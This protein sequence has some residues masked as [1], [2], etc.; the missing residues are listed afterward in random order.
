LAILVGLLPFTFAGIGTR[1]AAIVFFYR[2]FLSAPVAAA[3][4]LLF[5]LRYLVPALA[6][7]PLLG[8]YMAQ[9]PWLRG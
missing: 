8:R 2:S 9:I 1:D 3:L 5:T 4:G 6:G 7:L